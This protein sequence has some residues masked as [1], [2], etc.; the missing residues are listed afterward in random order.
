MRNKTTCIIT[1][2]IVILC[3]LTC[4]TSRWGTIDCEEDTEII[5]YTANDGETWGVS[6]VISNYEGLM[7]YLSGFNYTQKF[8]AKEDSIEDYFDFSHYDYVVIGG[9]PMLFFIK[10]GWDDCSSYDDSGLTPII[11]VLG[12]KTTRKIYIYK[13]TPKN[14]YRYMCG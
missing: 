4:I 12:K 2:L 5:W 6:G 8:P 14:K 7:D 13:I 11:G 10:L 1:Y 9:Q 3:L